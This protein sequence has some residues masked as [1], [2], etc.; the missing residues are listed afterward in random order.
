MSIVHRGAAA[1]LLIAATVALGACGGNGEGTGGSHS[2]RGECEQLNDAQR[3]ATKLGNDLTDATTN[4]NNE[5]LSA[6][7]SKLNSELASALASGAFSGLPANADLQ[8]AM[9][10]VQQI[11]TD[12]LNKNVAQASLDDGALKNA[13]SQLGADCSQYLT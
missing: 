11:Q 6:D 2:P 3:Q 8:A 10:A 4:Q 12:L 1:T 7:A 9:R 5:A 13:M